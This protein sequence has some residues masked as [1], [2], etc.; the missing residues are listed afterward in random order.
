MEEEDCEG[1]TPPKIRNPNIEI[2][3]RN[4]KKQDPDRSLDF[5]SFSE[6]QMTAASLYILTACSLQ[7]NT[8]GKDLRDLLAFFGSYIRLRDRFA[9]KEQNSLGQPL[10]ELHLGDRSPSGP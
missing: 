7:S 3:S 4:F 5:W 8:S 1:L 2:L 10:G 6:A 9:F